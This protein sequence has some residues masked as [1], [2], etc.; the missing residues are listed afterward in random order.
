MFGTLAK[1]TTAA[2]E[3]VTVAKPFA[4]TAKICAMLDKT[5]ARTFSEIELA[6]SGT[7]TDAV[8]TDRHLH[9][10]TV[11]ATSTVAISCRG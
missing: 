7:R 11:T 8:T 4:S 5:I 9:G 3:T 6:G 2:C 10:T 1:I